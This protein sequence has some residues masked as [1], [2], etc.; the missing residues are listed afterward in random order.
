MLDLSFYSHAFRSEYRS[1]ISIYG[2]DQYVPLLVAFKVP[3][4]LEEQER[5]LWGRI[6]GRR[7][8]MEERV[9]LMGKEGG[10]E[11]MSPPRKVLGEFVR[12]FEWP[13]GEE[14]VG[15]DVI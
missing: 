8:E 7:R 3:G 4:S 10:G 15:V 6:E 5:V 9:T 13:V 11:G 12:G 2:Q 14:E 1:L